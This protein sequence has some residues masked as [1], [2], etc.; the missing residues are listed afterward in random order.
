MEQPSLYRLVTEGFAG[1]GL[2]HP[3]RQKFIYVNAWMARIFAYSAEEI[4]SGRVVPKTWSIPDDPGPGAGQSP[5]RLGAK[6]LPC[7]TP[8]GAGAGMAPRSIC[9]VLGDRVEYQ[10]QSRRWWAP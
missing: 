7:T 5:P 9:E 4:L 10:G 1:W 6:W 2:H 3:G 8:S